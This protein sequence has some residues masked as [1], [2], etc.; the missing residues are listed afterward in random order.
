MK[1]I[2]LIGTHGTGKSTLV[3]KLAAQLKEMEID[4]EALR[5][6]ARLCPLPINENTT[7]KSQEWIIYNQYIKEIEEQAN[8]T[9]VLICDRSVLDGYVYYY[10]QI[11]ENKIIENFIKE[12]IQ[13][14]D[15]I[16]KVP[17]YFSKLKNDG[18]R[19]TN[20]DFQKSIDETFNYL[21]Y[22]LNINYYTFSGI[23][24]TAM[25]IQKEKKCTRFDVLQA[26][27]LPYKNTLVIDQLQNLKKL[28]DVDDDGEDYYWVLEDKKGNISYDS[29]VGSFIPLKGHLDQKLYDSLIDI[30]NKNNWR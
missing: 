19:S 9:D 8:N 26:E 2:A 16:W 25:S 15:Q 22:K 13:T 27:M 10:N 12:K 6:I 30:W 17:I 3:Y 1:K 7:K 14:Y 11:G 24:E 23:E 21:L 18:F 4:T 20:K 5:E 28:V 29:A